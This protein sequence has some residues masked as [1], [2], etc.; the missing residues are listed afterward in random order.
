MPLQMDERYERA[1][2]RVFQEN[3]ERVLNQLVTVYGPKKGRV[4]ANGLFPSKAAK[5]L[6]R[7]SKRTGTREVA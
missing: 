3:Y 5:E 4:I 1:K 7:R 6:P 2:E